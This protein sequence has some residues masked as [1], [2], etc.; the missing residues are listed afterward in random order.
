M[1]IFLTYEEILLKC[2]EINA[3][4]EIN[5]ERFDEIVDGI[6]VK[7]DVSADDK[8]AQA[9]AQLLQAVSE[10]ISDME[11]TA[12]LMPTCQ[13]GCAFC[14]YFPI[15][16]NKME[17]MLIKDAISKM[18]ADRKHFIENH[19][20]DYY[21]VYEEKVEQLSGIDIISDPD[22]KYKYKKE[23]LPC[24]FLNLKTNACMVYEVRP[25]PCRTYVNYTN[26]KVCADNIMP[27]ET[28]SYE[29]LYQE[30][31]GAMNELLQYLYEND[32]IEKMDYPGDLYQEGLLI[33][34]MKESVL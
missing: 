3:K 29:F 16:T 21:Q 4:Y 34:W 9:F 28:I 24:P 22:A 32:R 19:L 23:Q 11:S 30:Y 31:M 7:E 18:P 17:A 15:I 10:E 14:C 33:N 13:M 20:S 2:E 26:P 12:D 25:L 8:I 27:K 5:Q 1:S 6:L